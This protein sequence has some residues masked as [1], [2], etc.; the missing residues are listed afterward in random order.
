MIYAVVNIYI[1]LHLPNKQAFY[2][3]LA[4]VHVYIGVNA[5]VQQIRSTNKKNERPNIVSWVSLNNFS[6]SLKYS[7]IPLEPTINMPSCQV[8]SE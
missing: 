6:L 4:S 8:G 2:I 1:C 7:S 5:N 3:Q